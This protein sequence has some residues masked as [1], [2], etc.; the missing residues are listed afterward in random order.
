[1]KAVAAAKHHT[2]IATDV[3]EVFTW[4]SNRGK[5]Y[6]GLKFTKMLTTLQKYPTYIYPLL[7]G[8]FMV[9]V[10]TW[11]A[12][13]QGILGEPPLALD[14]WEERNIF[15]LQLFYFPPLD[16]MVVGQSFS[17]SVDVWYE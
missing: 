15:K 14:P 13:D 17:W 10:F 5:W 1:M 9:V 6:R 7:M 12:T 16:P 3:G 8:L 2:V 11:S 4:G